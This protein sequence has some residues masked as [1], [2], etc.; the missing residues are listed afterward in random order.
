[1]KPTLETLIKTI[2]DCWEADT[3]F[4]KD[5]QPTNPAKGHCSMSALTIQKYFGGSIAYSK[6]A[7]HY[8]NILPDG[9]LIDMTRS[10][11][12]NRKAIPFTE[13]RSRQSLLKSKD[14]SDRYKIFK[15]RVEDKLKQL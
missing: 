7:R 6:Q 15:K 14:I 3:S 12:S 9:T 10:Q 8:W 11:F 4:F 13:I 5:W 2:Q 1:M